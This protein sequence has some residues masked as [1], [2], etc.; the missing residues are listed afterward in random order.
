MNYLFFIIY[1]LEGPEDNT[2]KEAPPDEGIE[3]VEGHKKTSSHLQKLNEFR[4]YQELYLT[5]VLPCLAKEEELGKTLD[6]P[7]LSG[8]RAQVALDLERLEGI[9]SSLKKEVQTIESSLDWTN[10][11]SLI[12]E[13]K[14]FQDA[15]QETERI[16]EQGKSL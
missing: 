3:N 14:K 6:D 16:V 11:S 8:K 10:C 12:T 13:I 2:T 5:K 9:L 7:V 4:Q 15:L 1:H